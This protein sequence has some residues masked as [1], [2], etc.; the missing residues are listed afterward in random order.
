MKT[1]ELGTLVMAWHRWLQTESEC[2]AVSWISH[3]HLASESYLGHPGVD[4]FLT[5]YFFSP[6]SGGRFRGRALSTARGLVAP[7]AYALSHRWPVPYRAHGPC[8]MALDL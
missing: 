7:M 8:L 5:F 4:F 6:T 1:F 2:I 3:Q